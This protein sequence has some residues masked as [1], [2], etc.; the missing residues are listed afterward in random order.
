MTAPTLSNMATRAWDAESQSWTLTADASCR[1]LI[2]IMQKDGTSMSSPYH[3]NPHTWGGLALTE[4]A[5]QQGPSGS[6]VGMSGVYLDDLTGKSGD[7]RYAELL[8][9]DEWRNVDFS[10][11][12]PDSDV[13]F[14]DSDGTL[15]K[16]CGVTGHSITLDPDGR[17][18]IALVAACVSSSSSSSDVHAITSPDV[19]VTEQYA[20]AYAVNYLRVSSAPVL[21]S[22]GVVT[23]SVNF[24]KYSQEHVMVGLLL[25]VAPGGRRPS[26]IIIS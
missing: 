3:L 11:N 22:D 13:E 19:T 26:G 4:T 5:K 23:F 12:H 9:A 10:V 14:V 18:C 17:D 2:G 7:T 8:Y 20:G 16:D 25:G 6:E 24:Y 15:T 1:G 21:A